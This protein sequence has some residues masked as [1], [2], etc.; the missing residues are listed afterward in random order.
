MIT[1]NSLAVIGQRKSSYWSKVIYKDEQGN[2]TYFAVGF[3]LQ[4]L[5]FS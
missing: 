3:T 2:K 4:L 5:R 1:A